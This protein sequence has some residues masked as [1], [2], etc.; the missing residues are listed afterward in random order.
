MVSNVIQGE[1]EGKRKVPRG[2]VRVLSSSTWRLALSHQME[3]SQDKLEK[4]SSQPSKEAPWGSTGK[5]KFLGTLGWRG[6]EC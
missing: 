1:G 6:D 4:N 2:E 5:G 3:I